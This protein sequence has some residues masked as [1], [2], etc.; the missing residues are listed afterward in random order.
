MLRFSELNQ[1]SFE[2]TH[3]VALASGQIIHWSQF[4]SDID[5][6]R[7]G[8]SDRA[9]ESSSWALFHPN[10]YC[11]AVGLLALLAEGK[12]VYLPG[13][14]HAGIATAMSELQVELIGQFP[15]TACHEICLGQSKTPHRSFQLSGSIVIYTSGST[16][17]AKPI[18]KTLQQVEAELLTLEAQWGG[19]LSDSIFTS[20]VSHQHVYGL[21][22]ALL[23]PLCSGRRFWHQPFLD[24]AIMASTI[25]S[26]GDSVWV[27]SPAHLHRLLPNIPWQQS[28]PRVRTVFSSGGPLEQKYAREIFEHLERYPIEVLGSSETGGIAFRQQNEASTPWQPLPG[29]ETQVSEEGALSVR[30]PW[31]EDE[32]WYLTSD[33]ATALEDGYF[34]LGMRADRIVKLEGKRVAMPEVET[35]LKGHSWINEA[36]VLVVTRKRQALGAIIT[37]TSQGS[38]AE[39]EM[40]RHLFTSE[41]RRCLRK[42]LASAA[43]PRLWRVVSELPSNAQGKVLVRQATALF[44]PPLLPTIISQNVTEN[45]CVLELYIDRENPYFEGHFPSL[46]VLP[47]VTQLL[48]AQHFGTT[49]LG[50]KGAFAGLKTVKF[51][52]LVFPEQKLTLRL[53]YLAEAGSLKFYYDSGDKRHSQGTVLFEPAS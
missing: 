29:V 28:R 21:L 42:S 47:G 26:L 39:I 37:L 38:A 5:S 51:R 8:I 1:S 24:P 6:A 44:D 4:V 14:N 32:N 50:V 3:P 23:W 27:M 22:F 16:G 49:L 41:L 40:G 25:N 9:C 52:D 2:A 17:E 11:F 15:S 13:D 48:W 34:Q 43:V 46:P 20:T 45:V 33:T 36:A 19:P 18:R 30:S 10:T 7:S 53:E 35:A 12:T 31:L